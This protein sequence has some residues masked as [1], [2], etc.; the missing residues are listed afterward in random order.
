M[1]KKDIFAKK[2]LVNYNRNKSCQTTL[3]LSDSKFATGLREFNYKSF[4]TKK[5]E[6]YFNINNTNY[7][8]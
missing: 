8:S 7:N 6:I 1:A 4:L 5:N 2:M 3:E